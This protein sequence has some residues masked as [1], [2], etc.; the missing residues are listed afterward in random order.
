[1]SEFVWTSCDENAS[2]V[3][4]RAAAAE[5]GGSDWVRAMRHVR[6]E[7]MV[8]LLVVMDHQTKVILP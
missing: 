1:M 3:D 2:H 8:Y 6:L 4:S 7:R 5:Q